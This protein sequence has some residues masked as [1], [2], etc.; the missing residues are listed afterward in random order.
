MLHLVEPPLPLHGLQSGSCEHRVRIPTTAEL[1]HRAA[2]ATAVAA[3]AAAV[4]RPE[5]AARTRVQP[6]DRRAMAA[7]RVAMVRQGAATATAVAPARVA[8]A[9]PVEAFWGQGDRVRGRW[10]GGHCPLIF[11]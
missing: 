8:T 3:A 5:T 2:S 11:V 6:V 9:A 4:A 10:A 1:G 7:T